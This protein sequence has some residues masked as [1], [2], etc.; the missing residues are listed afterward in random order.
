[1]LFSIELSSSLKDLYQ[2]SGELTSVVEGS[3]K[4]IKVLLPSKDLETL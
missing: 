3:I 2:Q 1:M 4:F